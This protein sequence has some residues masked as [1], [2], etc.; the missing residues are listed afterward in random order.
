MSQMIRLFVLFEGA[1]FV[2]ASL[3]H[4][5]VL[6]GGYEHAQAALAESVIAVVLLIGFLLTW[7]WPVWTRPI[8]LAVQAFALL[9]TLVG[10]STIA[11]GVGPRTVPDVAYH[12]TILVVLA[13][14]LAVAARA[15]G[16]AGPIGSAAD[17]RRSGGA[18]P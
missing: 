9:G 12:L 13:W 2:L 3:I 17:T 10:V 14:G 16:Q 4:R 8:G 6:I 5:G 11:I 15:P 7:I 1:T 18:T